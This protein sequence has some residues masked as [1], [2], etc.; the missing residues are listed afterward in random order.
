MV[1]VFWVLRW[2]L[3]SA[4][5]WVGVRAFYPFVDVDSNSICGLMQTSRLELRV[6]ASTFRVPVK[7]SQSK[8]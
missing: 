2:H 6:M 4:E 5:V 1:K 3:S 8:M 7:L